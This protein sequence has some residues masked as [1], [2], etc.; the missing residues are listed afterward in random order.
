MQNEYMKY[1]YYNDFKVEN[2]TLQNVEI[3]TNES[4]IST[5]QMTY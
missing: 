5:L 2:F 1:I 4:L 3:K